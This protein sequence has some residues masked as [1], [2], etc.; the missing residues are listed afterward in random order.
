MATLV[1][2]FLFAFWITSIVF[3]GMAIAKRKQLET[4]IFVGALL[5]PSLIFIMFIV[6]IPKS[7]TKTE[8]TNQSTVLPE[9]KPD[10]VVEPTQE[11]QAP[12]L[13]RSQSNAISEAESYLNYTSF[14]REGLIGQLEYEGY[15]SADAAFAV[16][17]LSVDWMEQAVK[18]AESYLNYTSFSRSGLV[19]QL[20]YEKFTKE[21]AEY[22]VEQIYTL[23]FFLNQD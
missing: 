12:E 6:S 4:K 16:D 2:L 11:P 5:L 10:A 23:D 15:S 21:Q 3:M 7:D 1:S 9:P 19:D 20:L 8:P 13:T 18:K 22:G 14:S 17:Y